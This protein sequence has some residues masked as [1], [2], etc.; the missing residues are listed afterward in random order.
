RDGWVIGRGAADDKGPL[1][2]ALLAMKSL[3]ESGI[4]RAHTIRLLVGSDEE[5]GGSDMKEYLKQHAPPDY[6]LVLDSGFP[7]IVG[8]KAWNALSLTTDLQPRAIRGGKLPYEVKSLQAGIADSIV[9][10]RAVL[11]LGWTSG[12]PN[13]SVVV[14]RLKEKSLPEGTRLE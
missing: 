7:V 4:H 13:W 3:K 12:T 2:Q 9:P 8:E 10:D 11:S 14:A 6:S 1:V 5:T